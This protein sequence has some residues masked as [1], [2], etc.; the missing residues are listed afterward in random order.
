M[1]SSAV[2]IES[3]FEYCRAR[4]G[5]AEQRTAGLVESIIKDREENTTKLGEALYKYKKPVLDKIQT[6]Q[7]ELRKKENADPK[8]QEELKKQLDSLN[9][10]LE[11][12]GKNKSGGYEAGVQKLIDRDEDLYLCID[13]HL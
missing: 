9:T 12:A 1:Y 5:D 10:E 3:N 7:L 2:E 13:G 4:Q 6:V 11:N 8:K